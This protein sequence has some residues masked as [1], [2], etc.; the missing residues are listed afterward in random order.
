ML[1]KEENEFVTRTGP[2]TPMGELYRR[3]WLPALLS[4]ELPSPDCPPV[5]LTI[6]NERLVAFKDTNGRIGFLDRRCPHR[7]ADLFFGR[8]EEGGLRCIYHGWKY[9]VDGNCLEL[10]NDPQGDSFKDKIKTFAA[11]PGIE[12][13]GVIWIYMGPRDLKPQLPELEWARVPDAHRFIRKMH[14]GGNFL[15]TMEGDIDSSHVGFLHSVLN[16]NAKDVGF[17]FKNAIPRPYLIRDKTPIWTIKDTEYGVMLAA[18]RKAEE[19]TYHWRV[20]QWMIPSYT[21]IGSAPGAPYQ[22]NI[23]VPLDDEHTIYFRLWWNPDRPLAPDE[24]HEMRDRGVVAPELIPGTFLTVENESNDYLIDRA[25]QRNYSFTGI[26]SIPA[27]DFAVQADQGGRIMDRSLEHA[28]SGDQAILQVR[29]RLTT[30]A[31]G[32][33]EGREPPEAHNGDVYRIRSLDIVLPHDASI[34]TEGREHMVAEV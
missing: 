33:Q 11:Y 28:V 17:I 2:G 5:R 14:I 21:L 19:G 29:R 9:D 24:L 25:A 1:T 16:P 6:L 34:E 20:G 32:L 4:E 10:P 12:R 7:Q 15:Q 13:G 8:N 3:F 27:Q 31:R 30:A 18:R 22:C 26:K 23:R